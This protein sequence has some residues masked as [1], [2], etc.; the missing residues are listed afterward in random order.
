[1]SV[2]NA[3][4]MDAQRLRADGR[5]AEA[6]DLLH[7][8]MRRAPPEN[9]A[10]MHNYAAAL[11]DAGRN[12]EAVDVLRGAFAKGLAAPESHLVFGRVL[13]ATGAF[14]EAEAA[15]ERILAI[16][17][18]DSQ[19]HREL[20]QLAW[21]RTGDREAAL[22]RIDAAVAAHPDDLGLATSRAQVFGQTGDPETQYRLLKDIADAHPGDPVAAQL[23][24]IA[25]LDVGDLAAAL[26]L[27]GRAARSR[28]DDAGAVNAHISALLAVGD[29]AGAAREAETML[30]KMPLNQ[31][32]LAH[33]ATAW[34]LL[35]DERYHVLYDYDAFVFAGSLE[36]PKGWASLD[37]YLSDLREGLEQ[38]HKFVTH[39]FNQSV[40]H[41]SQ[42]PSID[43]ASHPA[44]RAYKE[45]AA[46]V[47]RAYL[48]RLAPGGDP[49][50]RRTL[51]SFRFYS[52]WSIKLPTNGFHVNHVHPQ[53]WLS[54]ACHVRPA[55]PDPENDK[56]G[57]LKFGEPGIKTAPALGPERYHRPEA[58]VLAL[59]PSYMWHGTVP[60][61]TGEPRL[62]IAADIVPSAT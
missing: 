33:L 58:G 1:M 11:G 46:P 40:R 52:L 43:G 3:M 32:F 9:V 61:G 53:G 38:A 7:E 51:A 56:A 21:M 54:S 31:M 18:S 34:R 62:T 14:E 48:A 6:V 10:V 15:F 39:P 20:A 49:L 25:A 44:L 19:A 57:W 29:A 24:S 5:H 42:A 60:F 35:G 8:V 28:P 12:E 59:F 50:R 55:A 2:L 4:T 47:V 37:G 45:A 13:A 23:A 36:A 17:P 30:G 26:D 16:R 22:R 41:G 27:G